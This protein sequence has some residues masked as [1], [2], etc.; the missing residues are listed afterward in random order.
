MNGPTVKLGAGPPPARMGDPMDLYQGQGDCVGPLAQ[1]PDLPGSRT[2]DPGI[3]ARDQQ[4]VSREG[5]LI[6]ISGV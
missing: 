4:E 5:H 1:W 6:S 3:W 2:N